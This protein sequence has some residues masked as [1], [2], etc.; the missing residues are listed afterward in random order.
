MITS[1][2]ILKQEVILPQQT[3]ET[4]CH[5]FDSIIQKAPT[6]P[7]TKRG[8]SS[9]AQKTDQILKITCTNR[10]MRHHSTHHRPEPTTERHWPENRLNPKISSINGCALVYQRKSSVI[11]TD[12]K[13]PDKGLKAPPSICAQNGGGAKVSFSFPRAFILKVCSENPPTLSKHS[14]ASLFLLP[15]FNST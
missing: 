6:Q 14:P 11:A 1:P 13:T 8:R 2:M 9:L 7:L 3:T 12:Q 5:R 10:E 4:K 15:H